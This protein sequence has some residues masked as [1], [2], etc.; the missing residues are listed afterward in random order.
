VTGECFVGKIAT[1]RTSFTSLEQMGS[2]LLCTT[3]THTDYW[4]KAWNPRNPL[5]IRHWVTLWPYLVLVTHLQSTAVFLRFT[6]SPGSHSSK[7]THTLV[8][9]SSSRVGSG[10]EWLRVRWLA[11]NQQTVVVSPHTH[12]PTAAALKLKVDE[13]IKF[14][15]AILLWILNVKPLY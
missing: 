6:L 13:L 9:P 7:S 4:T 1:L 2:S 8:Y 5:Y 15:P 11:N 14:Y 10:H 3:F 12:R